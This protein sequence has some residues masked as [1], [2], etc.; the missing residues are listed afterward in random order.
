MERID[1]IA[2]LELLEQANVSL[3]RFL[4]CHSGEPVTGKE[5][6]VEGLRRVERTLQSV[7]PFLHG[8]IQNCKSPETR[9]ELARYRQNLVRLQDELTRLQNSALECQARVLARQKHL[10]ASQA[11]CAAARDMTW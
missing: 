5:A 8:Q 11:W 3:A 1:D 6:E 4:D 9:K 10:Q 7:G 2:D